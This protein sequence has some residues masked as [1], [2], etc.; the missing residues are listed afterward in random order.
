MSKKNEITEEKTYTLEDL[1]YFW[2]PNGSPCFLGN[3]ENICEI[4][5]NLLKNLV[6][7]LYLKLLKI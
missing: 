3:K 2:L 5:E 6:K 7:Q 1:D 4:I